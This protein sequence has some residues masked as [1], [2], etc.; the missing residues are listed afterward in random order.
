MKLSSN[1]SFPPT[2]EALEAITS[3]RAEQSNLAQF[4]INAQN[5]TIEC[6]RFDQNVALEGVDEL[7]PR[8]RAT[9]NLYR[10]PVTSKDGFIKDY[11][12][13]FMHAISSLC[14]Y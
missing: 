8:D 1:V 7:V 9:Y 4:V 5:E 10:V 12:V 13:L 6:V 14:F 11:P 3:F 2:D